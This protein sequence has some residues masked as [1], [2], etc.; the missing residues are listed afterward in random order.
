MTHASLFS[1]IGGFDLAAEWAGWQ[2][3]MHCEINPFCQTILKHYWPHATT[4]TDITKTDFTIWRGRVDVLSGGFPCQPFSFAGQRQGTA[5]PRH[6]WPEMLRA[7]REIKPKWVVGE[8]VFG[9]VNW[10]NGLVF[11][12]VQADME[13][14]GYQVQ[15]YILPA[16]AVNA[17]HRRDRVWFV[18]YTGGYGHQPGQPKQ[19]RPTQ[20]QG[21]NQR[22]KWQRVWPHR[23]RACATRAT[24]HTQS[25]RHRRLRNT[26]ETARPPKGCQSFRGIYRLPFTTNTSSPRFKKQHTTAQPNQPRYRSWMDFEQPNGWQNFPTEPPICG[27]NDGISTELDRVTISK[28]RNES[29]KAYGNAIVPQVAL[30]IFKSINQYH[31]Q[32]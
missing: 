16:C 7:I 4:Y 22:H 26:G 32:Q 14:E 3:V 15:A 10:S 24:A 18:A 1:G 30:Q 31:A 21:Q 9:L 5:D 6:L 27:R 20:S 12:Q 25:R 8:N 28:W 13:S 19:D 29:I 2:N 17:P 23:G 11:Q